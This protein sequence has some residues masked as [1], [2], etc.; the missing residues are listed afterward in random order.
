MQPRNRRVIRTDLLRENMRRICGA[1]D[2]KVKVLAVVKAD[3]TM[4]VGFGYMM[5]KP[6][7]RTSSR[8]NIPRFKMMGNA[9][10]SEFKSIVQTA[11]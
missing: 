3:P 1:V 5:T 4:R 9:S 11:G 7:T 6:A 10:L 8:Y 2:P